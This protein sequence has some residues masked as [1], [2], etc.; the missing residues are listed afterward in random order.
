MAF[1][2]DDISINTIIGSGSAVTGNIKANGIVRVD[3]D[4]DG[5]IETTGKIIINKNSRI[6]G[7]VIASSVISGGIIEGDIIAPERVQLLS[8][9]AVYGDVS[10]KRLEIEENVILHGYCLSRH[11]A[12]TYTEA[13]KKRIDRKA[14]RSRVLFRTGES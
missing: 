1:H 9:G 11:D 14:I 4:I 12:E 6:K 13:E 8:T 5:N 10:T 3:G 2:T 7:N